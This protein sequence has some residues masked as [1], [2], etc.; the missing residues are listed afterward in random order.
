M[1]AAERWEVL[2]R[3][4]KRGFMSLDV[5]KLD[6]RVALITGGSRG[7]G[8]VMAKALAEAGADVVVTSR[9]KEKALESA[10]HLAEIT[11]RRT[12]G[13]A[14][15]VTNVEQIEAMV[16]AVV[17]EFGRIDILVNNAGINVRKPVEELDEVSWDLVQDTNLKAPFLCSRAAARSDRESLTSQP[18]LESCQQLVRTYPCRSSWERWKPDT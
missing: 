10:A 13:L 14:V 2:A 15:D 6:G 7:L 4:E 18:C 16:H 1:F 8:F 17:K 9:Q 11:K 12:L 5:F 3:K